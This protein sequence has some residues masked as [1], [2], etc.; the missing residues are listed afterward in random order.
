M[1]EYDKTWSQ[2]GSDFWEFKK[3]IFL[4]RRNEFCY[5]GDWMIVINLVTGVASQCYNYKYSFN[6]FESLERPVP[7]RAI[8]KCIMPHCYNGHTLLTL[9]C[10]PRFTDIKYG[11]IRNRVK[12]DGTAW[13]QPELRDFLNTTLC[14]SN[15]EYSSQKKILTKLLN[16]SER[17]F[18]ISRILTRKTKTKKLISKGGNE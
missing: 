7:F 1:H 11:N 14:E 18:R 4:K 5:A 16:N 8:G 15:M 9:G 12:I 6:I 13:L 10:I 17:V 3:S 2:F